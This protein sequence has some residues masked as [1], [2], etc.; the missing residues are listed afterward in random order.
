M[1]LLLCNMEFS[2]VNKH[3]LQRKNQQFFSWVVF[4]DILIKTGESLFLRRTATKKRNSNIIG[5]HQGSEL[6]TTGKIFSST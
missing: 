3:K 6:C 5:L 4:L 2:I 1:S